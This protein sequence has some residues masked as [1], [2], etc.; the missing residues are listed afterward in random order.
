MGVTASFAN[1]ITSTD[2]EGI[3]PKGIDNVKRSLLDW[4]GCA[5]AGSTRRPARIIVEHTREEGGTAQARL[6]ASGVRTTS[7]NAAF[8]N[9]VMG[10][11]EDFDDSG[12]HPA[13]YLTPTVLALGEELRL[14]GKQ[15]LASW[16]IGY[17]ISAHIA[18]G[19]HP[20]RAWHTTAIYGTIGATAAA[21]K[22]MGLD[23][24]HTRM[25]LG[26]GASETA[27]LMRNFGTM[28]KAF[29]PGNAARSGVVAAKLAARGY[30]ADP[31]IIEARYGYADCFGGEKCHLPAMTQFLGEV[32]LIAS[33][34]PAIKAWPTCSSN[35]QSLTGIMDLL[36]KHAI[37]AADI[38]RVEHYGPNVPGT[39][40]LQHREV[41][42]GQEGKFCLEY[43]IAAAFI[44]KRVDLSTFSD[45]RVARGDLQAFMKKVYRYQDP[46]AAIH[47]GRTKAALDVARL[48]ILLKDG[49]THDLKLGPRLTLT[50]AAVAEKFRTNAGLVLDAGAVERVIELVHEL[51]ALSDITK[52]MDALTGQ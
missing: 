5:L 18:A 6:I 48:K 33:K 28:T 47:S 11:L 19:L 42:N 20:D 8:A 26:I 37:E 1:W 21:C 35:H 49:T 40:S 27:G 14:P 9:G 36:Q 38:A 16:A 41:R 46:E 2:Y 13:S 23:A 29:H 30:L 50:G 51:D 15:I 52:L 25:A 17:D 12:A 31:D 7:T 44:D 39:G 32:S 22:L 45:E 10:H 43:N 3:P 4:I 34:C 24:R